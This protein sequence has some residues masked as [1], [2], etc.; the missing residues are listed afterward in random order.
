MILTTTGKVDLDCG[1]L[2]CI[3]VLDGIPLKYFYVDKLYKHLYQ[4]AALLNYS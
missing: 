2:T 4:H 1:V 3:S